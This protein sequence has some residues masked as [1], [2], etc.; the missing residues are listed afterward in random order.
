MKYKFFKI[1]VYYL[2]LIRFILKCKSQKT[3]STR[4]DNRF[5]T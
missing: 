2:T 5:N 3:I 4:K 1:Y